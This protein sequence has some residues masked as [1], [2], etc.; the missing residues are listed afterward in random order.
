MFNILIHNAL[1]E[2]GTIHYLDLPPPS[3]PDNAQLDP[4][5]PSIHMTHA[6]QITYY[7]FFFFFSFEL[8]LSVKHSPDT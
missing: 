4:Y 3:P 7:L 8:S 2:G 6:H 5:I 1:S